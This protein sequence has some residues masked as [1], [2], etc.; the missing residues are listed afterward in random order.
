M[1]LLTVMAY[2]LVILLDQVQV[3][4]NG[5]KKDF[6]V[7]CVMCFLSFMIALLLASGLNLPSP[8]KPIEQWVGRLFGQ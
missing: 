5:Y 2:V 7:S 1:I 4:K 3:Y 6:Y 8:S